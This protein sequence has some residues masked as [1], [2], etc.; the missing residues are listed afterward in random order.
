MALCVAGLLVAALAAGAF[1]EDQHRMAV[2]VA[3]VLVY[4]VF[5]SESIEAS[6]WLLTRTLGMVSARPLPRVSSARITALKSPG[7]STT[8][9][10][11][12]PIGE[13]R[14][15]SVSSGAPR[16]NRLA[17]CPSR[18]PDLPPTRSSTPRSFISLSVRATTRVSI[19]T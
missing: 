1:V 18:S 6:A 2:V 8:P 16:P 14:P 13:A 10:K 3:L 9:E 11:P 4:G 19:I 7:S 12:V 17:T 5:R 15:V